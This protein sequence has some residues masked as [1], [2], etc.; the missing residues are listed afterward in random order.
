MAS[1][2]KPA[3]DL[4][5]QAS[6]VR[7]VREILD[8][9]DSLQLSGID[10]VLDLFDHSLGTDQVGQF[11]DDDA[12]ATRMHLLDACG[13]PHPER[14]LARVVGIANTIQSDDLAA[15][16]QVGSRN[17]SHQF[18]NRGVR[19]LDQVAQRLNDFHQV[20]RRAVGSHTHRDPRSAVDQQ[21]GK[22]RREY[23]RLD[24]LAVVIRFEVNSVLVQAIGHGHRG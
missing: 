20:V 16:R 1:G 4:D 18:V 11:G 22:G 15:T 12:L 23:R 2:L 3:L 7:P 9:S 21:V 17:E 24:I 8:V 6:S 14:S 13:R 10:E 19:M 5:H